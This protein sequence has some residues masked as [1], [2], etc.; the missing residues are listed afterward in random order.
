MN[1]E[2]WKLIKHFQPWEF[3]CKCG[4]CKRDI[5]EIMDFRVVIT[6]DNLRQMINK[7]IIVTSGF[8]C[9]QHNRFM[10]PPGAAHSFHMSG[11]AL[12]LY[13]VGYDIFQFYKL[14]SNFKHINGIG[15]YK[16]FV[17]IDC[18]YGNKS[19]WASGNSVRP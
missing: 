16:N 3:Q 5:K 11:M 4:K 2:Q 19:V 6:A 10:N 14:A 17:H 8:R 1:E 7:P 15:R 12:D 18:R 13:P 9:P